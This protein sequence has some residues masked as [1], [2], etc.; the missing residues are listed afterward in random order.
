M[1]TLWT[2]GLM[3]TFYVGLS[4]VLQVPQGGNIYIGRDY[5]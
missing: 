4:Q 5:K 3:L 1:Y 2:A